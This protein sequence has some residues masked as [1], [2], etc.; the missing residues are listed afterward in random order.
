MCSSCV[1]QPELQLG[2]DSSQLISTTP[3]TTTAPKIRSFSSCLLIYF[4]FMCA[5][6]AQQI[7]RPDLISISLHTRSLTCFDFSENRSVNLHPFVQAECP[8]ACR[9][10]RREQSFHRIP[11][12]GYQQA[13]HRVSV[14]FLHLHHGHSVVNTF[15]RLVGKL[16]I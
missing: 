3:P 11:H 8:A 5:Q 1:R 14:D 10:A 15:L 16:W 12:G 4:P 6:I 13:C 7:V 9:P 2:F